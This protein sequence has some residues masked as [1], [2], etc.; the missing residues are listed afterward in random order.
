MAFEN[1]NHEGSSGKSKH[2]TTGDSEIAFAPK[3]KRQPT[4]DA[5]FAYLLRARDDNKDQTYFLYR[6][7]EAALRRTLFPIGHL[8][9]AEVRVEAERRGLVTAARRESQGICFVGNVGIKEFLSQFVEAVPGEIIEQE[10]GRTVG[11]HDGAIFYT[12][13]QRHSLGVGGGL[14]YYVVGK[15]MDKNQVY[16]SHNLDNREF[17]REELKLSDVHWINQTPQRGKTYQARL[18]HR[19]PLIEC[20]M[21]AK[22]IVKLSQPERAVA[23]G[24][25]VVIYDG[26]VVLGGGVV[27]S[28]S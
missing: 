9:K 20:Q 23:A 3:S 14:P 21:T 2:P 25:S 18:R 7:T 28:G 13:G 19:A 1:L 11:Q 26:E 15:D 24:Q 22:N 5:G 27:S 16:V 8:T 6:V 12:F 4:G 17:W 10:T